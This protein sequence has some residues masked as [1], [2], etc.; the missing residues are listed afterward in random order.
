MYLQVL[1]KRCFSKQNT[2][3]LQPKHNKSK[4]KVQSLF[5]NQEHDCLDFLLQKLITYVRF[6]KLQKSQGGNKNVNLVISHFWGLLQL[7][8]LPSN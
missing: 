4:Q 6:C 1:P 3:P 7:F 2:K 8:I 5:A